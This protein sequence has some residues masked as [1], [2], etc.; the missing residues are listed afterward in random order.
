[1]QAPPVTT[2][3]DD[4]RIA[5]A[6]AEPTRLDGHH[7]TATRRGVSQKNFRGHLERQRGRPHGIVRHFL[8]TYHT[9]RERRRC[10]G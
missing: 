7:R 3:D 1:M 8:A 5:S 4:Q 9:P 2:P 10:N 6:V